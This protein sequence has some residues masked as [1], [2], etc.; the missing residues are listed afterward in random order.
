MGSK[1]PD[2]EAEHSALHIHSLYFFTACA[3]AVLL[4]PFLYIL[5]IIC[6]ETVNI[7]TLHL[8]LIIRVSTGVVISP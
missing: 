3:V 1:R 2:R 6:N 4:L 8:V 5:Q 7:F